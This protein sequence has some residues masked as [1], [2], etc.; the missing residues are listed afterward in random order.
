MNTLNEGVFIANYKWN[1]YDCI[2]TAVI[3]ANNNLS[4]K[5][6]IGGVKFEVNGSYTLSSNTL[7]HKNEAYAYREGGDY[8]TLDG[9]IYKRIQ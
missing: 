5:N 3:S 6:N 2:S 9:T 4:F 7:I 8:F 1:G